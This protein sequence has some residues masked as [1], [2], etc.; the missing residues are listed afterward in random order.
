[1]SKKNIKD[2][3]KLKDSEEQD[4]TQ[5]LEENLDNEELEQ[6]KLRVEQAENSHRRALA[7]YQNLQKRVSDQRSELILSANRDLL[8]RILSVLDTLVLANQHVENE[9]LK[10]AINQFLD[11]LKSEGV[12]R[13]ETEG[14]EFNPHTMECVAVD[15]GAENKIIEEMRAGYMLNDKVLRPA[16]VK[17]GKKMSSLTE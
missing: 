12:T 5:E 10:V 1:M 6:L 2:E 3:E 9:G 15:S 11:V 8:L 16:Q 17:V 14:A 13:I 4:K 7:D